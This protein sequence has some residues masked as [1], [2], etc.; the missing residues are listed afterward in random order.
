[1]RPGMVQLFDPDRW[2]IVTIDQRGAGRSTPHAGESAKAL[3]ANTTEHL[4]HDL[5]RLRETLGIETWYIYG[6]SWGTALGFVYALRHRQR[7]EG[8][9]LAA[10][11]TCA[12]N[13]IDFLYHGARRF[14]PDAHA[15][16]HSIVPDARDGI[17]IAAGYGDLLTGSDSGMQIH[18][19]RSWCAW[20]AAVVSHDPRTQANSAYEDD[21]F[22]LG[23]AR[24]V[25]HY[26]RNLA[27]LDLPLTAQVHRL[28]DLDITMIHSR[29]DLSTPLLT[30]WRL[31]KAMPSSKLVIIPG[32]LHATVY[33]PLSE[34]IIETGK[35]ISRI[36]RP[37]D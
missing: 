32:G 27:W 15:V 12:R 1:M 30:P 23:F 17:E 34:A 10:V 2:N 31:H 25:T 6:S 8:M 21:R 4:I 37:T 7:V 29:L 19:A 20:E 3:H 36:A 11:A 14:L 33:G 9:I 28:T 26:F 13:D 16:F 24:I 35:R 18:A 5:E 22:A